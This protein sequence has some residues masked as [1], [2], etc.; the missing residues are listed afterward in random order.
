MPEA[1]GSFVWYELMTTDT[2]AAKA[3]YGQAVGWGLQEMPE[4]SYTLFTAGDAPVG[5]LMSLPEDARKAGAP[6]GWL[7]YVAVEDVDAATARVKQ[8]GGAVHTPP[9]DI[10]NIGRFAVVADPQRATFALFRGQGPAPERPEPGTPGHVGWHELYA[11]DWEAAFEFYAALFGWRK[12]DAIEIGE[13]GIYQLFSAGGQTIGGMFNRLSTVPATFWLFYV[14]VA[15]ID[16]AA[17]RVT[18]GGGKVLNGP[19]QVP[20]GD[21]IVQCSDPQG[22]MFALVGKRA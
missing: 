22:A 9:T 21:W 7:G 20:G 19:M 15:D 13:T 6:P 5:G 17:G 14:N 16:A 12:A 8:L 3:F 1:T 4:M 11:D 18:D 10:P 2:G